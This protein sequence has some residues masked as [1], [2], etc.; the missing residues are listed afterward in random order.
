[1]NKVI[2]DLDDFAY[3]YER[4]ALNWLFDLKSKY[5][6]FKVTLFSIPALWRNNILKQVANLDWIELGVHG[7]DHHANNEVLKWDRQ[8]WYE[9]INMAESSGCYQK[10]FKA[11]NWEMSDLGYFI[12][13]ENDWAVAVREH[14]IKDLQPGSKYYCFETNPFGIH[15]HTWT[16]KAHQEEGKFNWNEDTQFEFISNNVEEK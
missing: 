15:G 13:K 8:K 7:F 14:Q 1:M 11:P 9:I 2:L 5:P 6:E 3:D 12:L 4:N 10:L 16:M